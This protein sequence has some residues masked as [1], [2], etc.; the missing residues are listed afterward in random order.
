MHSVA[1]ASLLRSLLGDSMQLSYVVSDLEASLRFWT[2]A[3]GTGP[4]VV[5]DNAADDRTVV[6]R[7]RRAK[8]NM[9]LAFSYVGNLQIEL[10]SAT[11]SEPTPWTDFL[12]S[13]REGLH[14]LGFWPQ[15]YGRSCTELTRMGFA[16]E[17]WI[18]TDTG[19]IS[20]NYF[21]APP[22]FGAMVELAPN[23]PARKRYFAGIKALANRW[24]GD[25]PVRRYKTR[26]DYL[27]SDDC[28]V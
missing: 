1:E 28:K 5:I 8:V 3:A 10:I 9:S 24:D 18:E 14:H 19:S 15:D 7:G 23:T 13:G 12:A 20:S 17:C 22:H 21:R 4:F 11:S 2:E 26:E 27:A 25:R 16:M 6:Y